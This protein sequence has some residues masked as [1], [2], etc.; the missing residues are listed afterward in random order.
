M[1]A[2][3]DDQQP[4]SLD[5]NAILRAGRRILDEEGQAILAK[6]ESLGQPFS[7]LVE[8]VLSLVG[9]VGVTGVGK[10]GI[11]GEK[12]AATLSST[13]TPSLFLKP[14]DAL[15][16]DLGVLRSDD[17]LIAISNS[18]ETAEVLAVATA[19]RNLGVGVAALTGNLESNLAKM[20][21]M[22][23][24]IGVRGE[25]CPLGL[26]PTTST[27]VT[28]A[29]GDALAM[30]LLELRGFTASSYAQFHP[31]GA[32]G[33]RLRFRVR[34]LMRCAPQIPVVRED[35]TFHDALHEMTG[36]ENLGVTLVVNESECLSGIL[37]DGDL[38]RVLLRTEGRPDMAGLLRDVM[39]R[40]PQVI[41]PD[42]PVSEALQIMEVRG[43]SSLAVVDPRD[44]PV[45]ILHLHDIFGRGKLV[46]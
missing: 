44:R 22:A 5:R 26:A 32:L 39:T 23:I 37:T 45:G 9:K 27:T 10:S 28:M 18:G 38:R 42:S 33:E 46:L 24:D 34:D 19:A 29:V 3:M 16:G 13:G 21:E 31:A 30:V 2:L 36:K 11:V 41:D 40:G 17:F 12:I 8:R 43:I 1:L 35:Q 14:V 7:E 25:A 20:A 6:K 4:P 15:H